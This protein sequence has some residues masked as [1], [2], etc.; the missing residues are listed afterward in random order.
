MIQCSCITILYSLSVLNGYWS[1][2][3]EHKKINFVMHEVYTGMSQSV[4]VRIRNYL[5]PPLP[6]KPSPAIYIEYRPKRGTNT[7]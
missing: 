7:K 2:G 3:T 4:S 6:P 5:P 1:E